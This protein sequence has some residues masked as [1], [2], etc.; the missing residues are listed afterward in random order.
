MSSNVRQQIPWPGSSMTRLQREA[1]KCWSFYGGDGGVD[2]EEGEVKTC[3][4]TC[5]LQWKRWQDTKLEAGG[6]SLGLFCGPDE[7]KKRTENVLKGRR[8][9]TWRQNLKRLYFCTSALHVVQFIENVNPIWAKLRARNHAIIG[10]RMLSQR[11]SH[12]QNPRVMW[13]H[14]GKPPLGLWTVLC[15]LCCNKSPSCW[16]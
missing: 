16:A 6:R 12:L 1:L 13:W 2:R 8:K 9:K 5:K 7:Y 10:E 14:K 4:H 3:H 11:F 15:L